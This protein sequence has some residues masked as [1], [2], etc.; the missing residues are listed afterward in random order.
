MPSSIRVSAVRNSILLIE[1]PQCEMHFRERFTGESIHDCP[2]DGTFV[3]LGQAG[4][5]GCNPANDK[6]RDC[7]EVPQAALL[8]SILDG[9]H[10]K[11]VAVSGVAL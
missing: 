1:R 4:L 2:F 6:K 5:L 7:N 9:M 11:M 8:L 10:R 3:V